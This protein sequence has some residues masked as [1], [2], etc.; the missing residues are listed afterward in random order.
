MSLLVT[1]GYVGV[2][3]NKRSSHPLLICAVA[4]AV[5]LVQA[6]GA[7]ASYPGAAGLAVDP[8]FGHDGTVI[9]EFGSGATG[10]ATSLAVE[11]S[12]SILVGGSVESGD[13]VAGALVRLRASGALDTTLAGTGRLVLPDLGPVTQAVPGPNGTILVS[14]GHS[15]IRLT[16]NGLP[17]SSFGVNGTAVLPAGFLLARFAVEPNGDIALIGTV[18]GA[19]APGDPSGPTGL[20]GPT[21]PT[22]ATGTTGAT[23]A[24]GATGATGAS[25]AS[26]SSSASGATNVPGLPPVAVAQIT[27]AGQPSTSFGSG[28]MVVLEQLTVPTTG[29]VTGPGGIAVAGDGSIIATLI[30]PVRLW[31]DGYLQIWTAPLIERITPAGTIDTTFGQGG[32][33]LVGGLIGEGI[34]TFAPLLDADGNILVA[35][36]VSEGIGGYQA[37][38]WGVSNKGVSTSPALQRG[39]QAPVSNFIAMPNGGSVVLDYYDSDTMF[40]LSY[41]P[42]NPDG[43]PNPTLGYAPLTLPAAATDPNALIAA[44]LDSKLIV[45]G[46]APVAGVQQLFVTRLFGLNR[47]DVGAPAQRVARTDRS[48]RVRLTCT[49]RESC[50]GTT[51]LTVMRRHRRVAL[52]RAA[53]DFHGSRVLTIKLDLAGRAYLSGR[54]AR[55]A[56]VAL[57]LLNGPTHSTRI[58]VPGRR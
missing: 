6:A 49:P 40:A 48:I 8:T 39:D 46:Q 43:P 9:V 11:P 51:A 54:H 1:G 2:L 55:R 44:Q 29:S 52:G 50:L 37:V 36:E 58:T 32:E 28:G 12:G 23:S 5:V 22:G 31:V 3:V 45:A 53:F 17:D 30:S 10:D 38:L 41:F 57:T 27:A 20:T 21:G 16:A 34:G 47:V 56:T 42:P 14:D 24:T 4:A 26:G 35:I 25:G 7:G 33:V 18:P 19:Q 15:L 13:N